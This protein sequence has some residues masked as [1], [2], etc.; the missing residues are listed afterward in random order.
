MIK[1]IPLLKDTD[2]FL[3]LQTQ[4]GWGRVLERF[5]TWIR[6]QAGWLALDVGCGPGLLPGL[7]ARSGCRAVGVDIDF[8]MFLPFP[9]HPGVLAA[10]AA[11]LPFPSHTFDL[12]TASNLLF[13]AD[14][15]GV[16]LAEMGCLLRPG[17]QVAV[18]NP[19]EHLDLAAATGLAD[20]RGLTGLARDTLLNW[21][22]RAE[23]HSRWTA[24]ELEA[25][26]EAA[27]LRLVE[28]GTSLGPGFA[29][30]GRGVRKSTL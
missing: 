13:L 5:V 14:E 9:L 25:L 16:M 26:F 8:A 24:G 21:A 22:G 11:R 29:R 4:T 27:D 30:F 10:E 6:P 23:D 7:L 18:L 19:S 3:E 12:V 17:G 15:P 28:T 2:Y 20:E 1:T